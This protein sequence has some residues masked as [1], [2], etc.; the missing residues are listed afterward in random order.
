MQHLQSNFASSLHRLFRLD[1]KS[2]AHFDH[3]SVDIWVS[4]EAQRSL[5]WTQ[6]DWIEISG[7]PANA[8]VSVD[9]R[10]AGVASIVMQHDYLLDPFQILLVLDDDFQ[11]PNLVLPHKLE[12]TASM[13]NQGIATRIVALMAHRAA[14]RG[15]ARIKVDALCNASSEQSRAN[16]GAYTFARLGFD[17]DLPEEIVAMLPESLEERRTVIDLVQ[18]DAGTTFWRENASAGP[19]IFDLGANSRSWTTLRGYLRVKKIRIIK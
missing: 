18:D 2:K 13:Q 14:A 8:Q 7:A 19:M 17:R 3:R 11:I 4:P 15:F 6:Q 10:G 16:N 5:Q 1:K 9:V 12:L